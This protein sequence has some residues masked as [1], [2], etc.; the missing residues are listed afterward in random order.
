MASKSIVTDIP[1][2]N[3]FYALLRNNP[4]LIIIKFGAVWCKYCKNPGY[5]KVIDSFFATSPDNVICCDIDVDK[6]NELYSLL[7]NKRMIQGVPSLLCYVKGNITPIPS[8]S[9][10]GID[11]TQLHAFFSRCGNI[12][13]KIRE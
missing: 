1:S 7:R 4:G 3:A 11:P 6:S 9:I 12:Q 10:S 13:S 8:D 5:V 2:I